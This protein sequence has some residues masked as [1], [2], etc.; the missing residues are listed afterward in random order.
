MKT[1][2]V[3]VSKLCDRLFRLERQGRYNEAL[4]E[5]G[6]LWRDQ[7]G[8]PDTDDLT[9]L[10][11]AELILRCGS[12][13]GFLGHNEQLP[14]S[15]EKARNLLTNARDLFTE[16]DDVEKIAECENNLALTYWRSGAV[17][18]A[19]IWLN[20]SF[21]RQL[22]IN[23]DAANYAIVIKTML[24]QTAGNYD[25]IIGSYTELVKNVFKYGD[26]FLKGSLCTNIAIAFEKTGN[27]S[28][29]LEFLQKA[30]FFHTK[31][32]HKIYL[33]TIQN[34]IAQIYKLERNFPEAY[35]FTDYAIAIF[36]K[37]KDRTREG[38]SLDTKANIYLAENRFESAL[39]TVEKAVGIL[40][41]G[42][43]KGYLIETYGTKIKILI[44]M[45]DVS[46]AT[47]CLMEAVEIAKTQISEE[48][49]ND[50]VKV[51]EIYLR[52]H[53][54]T[55]KNILPEIKT[56]ATT[57]RNLDFNFET[58]S[59]FDSLELILP[60]SLSMYEDIQ[61][62]WINNTHL[63]NVGLVRDSLAVVAPTGNIQRGDLIALEETENKQ[64]SCGFYDHGFGIVCLEDQDSEP[65]LF[66]EEKISIIGKI[67]GVASERTADGK[68]I[69]E[70]ISF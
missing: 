25:E 47:F 51:F 2:H 57:S 15:Q 61:G 17:N 12:V 16:L 64:V 41:P 27:T 3:K 1:L 65:L 32:R 68:L 48:A 67:I 53:L 4:S 8:L 44:A 13:F 62:V 37:I 45:D 52:E 14:A 28:K 56:P 58:A 35:K 55:P 31:S 29:A 66:D 39:K 34:N 21:S 63:E 6:D 19:E 36:K 26:D 18:E 54:E 70:P 24:W 59:P 38:F 43:N 50:L 23:S 46:N 42:E 7:I 5:I 10:S 60:S 69:V 33:G 22:P 49:A 11:A 20:E 9:P 30:H 40:A